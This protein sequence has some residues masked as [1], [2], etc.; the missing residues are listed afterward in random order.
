VSDLVWVKSSF[1]NASCVEV[2]ADNGRVAVRDSK[3]PDGGTLLYT[4]AEWRAFLAGVRNGEFDH[5]PD[6]GGLTCGYAPFP[7]W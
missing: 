3:D 6:G 2:A 5:L 4:G 7:A 1:S